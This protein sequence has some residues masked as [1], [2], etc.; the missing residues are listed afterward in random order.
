MFVSWA[1]VAHLSVLPTL[2]LSQLKMHRQLCGD[3]IWGVR[4]A[5]VESLVQISD[6][7]P[8]HVRSGALTDLFCQ[9]ANDPSRWVW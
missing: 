2:T 7:V 8:D 5:C 1:S 4:K 3:D 6:S 9:L